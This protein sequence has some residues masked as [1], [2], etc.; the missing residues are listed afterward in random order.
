MQKFTEKKKT[1]SVFASKPPK[2]LNIYSIYNQ[3][4]AYN[5]TYLLFENINLC[6]NFF[7]S[8]FSSQN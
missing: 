1:T 2:D 8:F 7:L 3:K 5:K 4:C 6:S